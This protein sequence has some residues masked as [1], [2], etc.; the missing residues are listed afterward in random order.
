MPGKIAKRCVRGPNG[1]VPGANTTSTTT[2]TTSS[3]S[4]APTPSSTWK[5]QTTIAGA[6]FFDAWT[7]ESIP[8]PTEGF[9]NYQTLG[10]SQAAG[11]IEVNNA[12]N[13]VMRMETTPQI[14]GNR[15]S[16]RIHSNY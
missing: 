15:S 11:L 6:H 8:D 14:T 5:I 12:G 10:G 4:A 2:S 1:G 16:V 7:F 9:V 3:T 13:A